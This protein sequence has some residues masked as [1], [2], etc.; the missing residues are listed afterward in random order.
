MSSP[1]RALSVVVGSKEMLIRLPEVVEAEYKLSV[2]VGMRVLLAGDKEPKN[3][4][5]RALAMYRDAET[6]LL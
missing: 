3:E 4:A 1:F 2:T 6:Y 5:V